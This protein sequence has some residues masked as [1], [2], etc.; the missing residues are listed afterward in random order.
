MKI[1]IRSVNIGCQLLLR[2]EFSIK[3]DILRVEYSKV[4]L[5]NGLGP[6]V[7]IPVYRA[8]LRE[9]RKFKPR[10]CNHEIDDAQLF[11]AKGSLHFLL[12][13][14]EKRRETTNTDLILA[15]ESWLG[16]W[17]SGRRMKQGQSHFFSDS[18][19][20]PWLAETRRDSFYSSLRPPIQTRK[21]GTRRFGTDY[22][23]DQAK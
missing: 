1:H 11:R 21:D 15:L 6:A 16:Q 12:L 4:S 8:M 9:N 14:H 13:P 22:R 23:D 7:P 18:T 10:S 2:T 19:I 3:D 5:R 17:L 20:L